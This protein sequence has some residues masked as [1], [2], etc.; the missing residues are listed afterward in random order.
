M[1]S[2]T[3]SLEMIKRINRQLILDKIK[4]EQLLAGLGW[5]GSWR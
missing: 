3:G 4:K 1:N 5:P 2:N